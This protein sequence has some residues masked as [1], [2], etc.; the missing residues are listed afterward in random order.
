LDGPNDEVDTNQDFDTAYHDNDRP[1]VDNVKRKTDRTHAHYARG[2]K[3]V[4]SV[5]VDAIGL[6]SRVSY[7]L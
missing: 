7:I 6:D 3:S 1:A 5:D 4:F 2:N